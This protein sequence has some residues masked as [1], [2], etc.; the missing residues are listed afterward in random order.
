MESTAM[1][2]PVLD[3]RR[4]SPSTHQLMLD[5]AKTAVPPGRRFVS[6]S[7]A[8]IDKVEANLADAPGPVVPLF[9]GLVRAFD[10][11]CL[12]TTG[13]R[14]RRLSPS[15]RLSFMRKLLAA[16]PV[17]RN[18]LRLLTAPV[19]AAHY[20]SPEIF[21][22]VGAE[23]RRPE[24]TNP[25]RPR[26]LERVF[27]LERDFDEPHEELEAEVVVVGSG[28]GGAA[29]AAEL[30]EQ[31]VAVVILEEGQ[32]HHR[33]AF[34][35][36][37][38]E[39]VNLLYRDFGVTGTLGNS[40]VLVP[41][42]KCV[43]G[44][45]TINSGTCYRTPERVFSQW[46]DAG[47]D[48]FS[49]DTMDP[50]YAKVESLIEVEPADPKYLGG[51]ADAVARGADALGWHDHGPLARNAP[52]CDAASL[53]PFG[54]PTDAKRSTNVSYV[55][56]ALRYGAN[57]VTGA[58]VT[59]VLFEGGRA[60]GVSAVGGGRRL[61]VRAGAVVLACGSVGTPSLLLHRGLANSSGQV[62]RNLSIHPAVGVMGLF[63]DEIRGYRAIPQGYG[64]EEFHAEGILFE[65]AN[66]PMDFGAAGI[67]MVGPRF[68]EIMENVEH[69]GFFGFLVEDTSRGRVVLGPGG[70]PLMLY[71][72][73]RHDVAQLKRGTEILC[74]L[75]L[76]AGAY[77][78]FP[79]LP[80]FEEIFDE[81][82]IQRLRQTRFR[83][84][85]FELTAHHPLGTCRMGTDPTHSVVG[86]DHQ[87]HDHRGLFICDGSSVPSSLGVNPQV[88]IMAMATRAAQFIA[89]ALES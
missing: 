63:P 8:T 1:P 20:D 89:D 17:R 58:R 48:A 18:L 64:M 39:M 36:R 55:P 37:P 68:T 21:A 29:V 26:Y 3:A 46:R 72:F 7:S 78:I 81:R 73:N 13:R 47:L 42:G 56:L 74:R 24:V 5:I 10:G 82:D 27:D 15:A 34:S 60:A 23:Y 80:G 19:K 49:S 88:T 86:P 6:V 31:G 87:T 33:D 77:G 59:R 9:S 16:D 28:A 61:T 53:C 22:A 83:A 41:L 38:M 32:Y 43:G 44:T 65:G 2:M 75:Y 76:A 30:A 4:F 14:F 12:A 52:G 25:E 69:L 40:P 79:Q 45:T 84:G 70:R 71:N 67:T 50:Y 85:D 62:G 66:V 54:C 51:I 35:G 57:L 11:L